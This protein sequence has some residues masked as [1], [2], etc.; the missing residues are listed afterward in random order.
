[1]ALKEISKQQTRRNFL[2][3]LVGASLGGFLFNQEADAQTQGLRKIADHQVA[4]SHFICD[5]ISMNEDFSGL[6]R[7]NYT[8]EQI[9]D[10][11]LEQ[12]VDIRGKRASGAT[13]DVGQSFRLV[14]FHVGLPGNSQI[15]A[16]INNERLP[17]RTS[18]GNQWE[19]YD[20]PLRVVESGDYRVDFFYRPP[21]NFDIHTNPDR[22][23]LRLPTGI[24][25]NAVNR[26][27]PGETITFG[28][29][30]VLSHD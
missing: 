24:K 22:R 5:S 18:R 28:G 6:R 9:R 19:Y 11:L 29:G 27:R 26:T 7:G 16:T 2:T 17:I 30:R 1:M 8:I 4:Y 3:S 12:A 10:L 23:F 25:Y 20:W 14:F 15:Y 21:A 13:L